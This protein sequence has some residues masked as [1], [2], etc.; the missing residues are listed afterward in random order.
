MSLLA[1]CGCALVAGLLG[2]AYA[3]LGDRGR[4]DH[5]LAPPDEAALR[6]LQPPREAGR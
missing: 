6:A 1:L 4:P 2:L 5:L 3:A